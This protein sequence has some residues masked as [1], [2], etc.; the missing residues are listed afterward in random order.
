MKYKSFAV[1]SLCSAL[2]VAYA[3]PMHVPGTPMMPPPHAT[4]DHDGDGAITQRE[5]THQ[6]TQEFLNADGD[7]DGI[8]S[9]K[10]FE[11]V[12]EK[13][14]QRQRVRAFQRLDVDG[15]GLLSDTEFNAPVQAMLS[16]VDSNHD[17][18]VDYSD[19]QHRPLRPGHPLK[20]A[21]HRHGF[22]PPH[23]FAH[24]RF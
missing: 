6:H 21:R 10:E 22:P 17:G 4:F 14:I 16:H 7:H 24:P 1:V 9:K 8:L 18:V 3:M 12:F 19:R 13:R 2:T 11:I 20:H 23:H 15:D 5:L